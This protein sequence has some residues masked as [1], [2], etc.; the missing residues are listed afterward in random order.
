MKIYIFIIINSSLYT[1]EDLKSLPIS[2][3]CIGLIKLFSN[4]YINDE[5]LYYLL[6]FIKRI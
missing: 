4:I 1:G 2:D 5:M 6:G 3:P